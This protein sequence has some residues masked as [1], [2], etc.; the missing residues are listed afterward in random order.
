VES[1][2]GDVADTVK[3]YTVRKAAGGKLTTDLRSFF[4]REGYPRRSD[5]MT[6]VV[7]DNLNASAL[8]NTIRVR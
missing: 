5:T 3:K 1:V 2:L 7:C 8:L 4:V 6:L